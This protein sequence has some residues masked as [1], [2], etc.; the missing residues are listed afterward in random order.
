MQCITCASAL[1]CDVRSALETLAARVESCTADV[2]VP[3]YSVLS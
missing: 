1:V 3:A 2:Q